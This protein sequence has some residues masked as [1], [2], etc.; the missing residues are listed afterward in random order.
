MHVL[1]W[2]GVMLLKQTYTL[3]NEC[4]D[5]GVVNILFNKI[6]FIFWDCI[7]VFNYFYRV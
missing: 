7:M 6:L 3:F 1:L 2:S 5:G 4:N